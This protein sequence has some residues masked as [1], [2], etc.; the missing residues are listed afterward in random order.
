MRWL[1]PLVGLASL[2][3]FLVR[4]ISKPSRATY[5]CQRVAAPLASGF[6][7]W[8]LGLVGSIAAARKANQYLRRSRYLIAGLCVAASVGALWLALSITTRRPAL[9]DAPTPNAPVGVAQG[10]HPGR[11]VWVH[12]PDA[13]DWE[14]PGDG[15]W[16]QPAHTDQAA[17]DRMMSRAICSLTGESTDAAAWDKLFRHFN[18]KRGR[19][20]VGYQPGEKI[21]IKVN[22][23]GM[24][25]RWDSVDPGTYDLTDTR[26][27]YMNTS[28][29]MMLALL[30]Q[31]VET[32]G[33]KQADIAIG[34]TLACFA[35]D[36]YDI[37]QAEFPD[38]RYLDHAGKFGRTG[39]KPSS[40]PLY[41]SCRP[42]GCLQDYVPISFAEAEYLINLANLK[43]HTAAGVT[44]CAKNH[45]GS[46]VRWPVQE[47]YYDMHKGVFAR[48]MG[49]YRELVDLLGH[50]HLGGK[51]V[52]Y[53]IDGLYPGRHPIDRA[54]M[55]WDSSPFDGDWG[56]SLFASQDP[57]AIDSVAFDFLWAEWDDHPHKSGAEDYLHEAAQAGNPPSGTFYDPNH[58]SDVTRLASL[59]V[60]E[61]WNNARD[62]HYSRNLGTGAGIELVRVEAGTD[63]GSRGGSGRDARAARWIL[64][65]NTRSVRDYLVQLDGLGIAIAFPQKGDKFLYFFSASSPNR[66]SEIRSVAGESRL[67]WPDRN[68][69]LLAPVCRELGIPVAPLMLLFLP[70]ELE[71]RFLK[72]ELGYNN[73]EE[74]QIESTTFEVVR[75]G[76]RYD[77]M[78]VTQEAR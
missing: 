6:V 21:A 44:L 20:D 18:Q 23:V 64:K 3:W 71:E 65:F 29:Q 63:K 52:L 77:V 70:V 1:L 75:R 56:S 73:L 50:A 69:A 4:V 62:K 43:S 22:F 26:I 72:L 59:G 35:N 10:I 58:A 7:V 48:G 74:D 60:H 45:Y 12:D 15:H 36:Y 68:A 55:R 37:L 34:D 51:T 14:G 54:P 8:L 32:V 33:A 78:V 53:L 66:T 49:K 67:S 5:P 19:G 24:I 47:G 41:W 16:W 2:V 57:V 25:W 27:D 40:V 61:H 17:V 13:T 31:L 30:R 42:E 28:P 9:A 11:V 39:V 76:G 38:V 46:L